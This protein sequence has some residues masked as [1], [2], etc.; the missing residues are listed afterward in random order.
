MFI[1]NG[2]AYGFRSGPV[3]SRLCRCSDD[4]AVG[5]PH[6]EVGYRFTRAKEYVFNPFSLLSALDSRQLDPYWIMTGSSR[7]LAKFL[8]KSRFRLEDLTEKWV[9]FEKLSTPFSV[10]NPLSLFFQTG[11]LTI[12]DFEDRKSVV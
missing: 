10:D 11:Y 4:F 5:H 9:S 8:K 2:I 12:R 6:N 3:V 7:I 1:I